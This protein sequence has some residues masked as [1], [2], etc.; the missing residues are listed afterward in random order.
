VRLQSVAGEADSGAIAVTDAA[1]I[2]AQVWK[3]SMYVDTN[4]DGVIVA[5]VKNFRVPNPNQA[6]TDIVYAC[7]EGPE[8]AVYV[9]G[10]ASLVSGQATVSLPDHF[11]SVTG[12]GSITAQ[13]TPL[14]SASLGLAVTEKRPNAIVVMELH[15][16]T[17]SYD[18]DWEVKAVRK[19]HE[20]YRVIRPSS[21]GPLQPPQ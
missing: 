9:R 8:A 15:N 2:A 16:G 14:S 6:N 11:A 19:G 18:F 12:A 10:T 21:E 4:G 5:G 3:A 20:N 7:I 1:G 13:V 17:G